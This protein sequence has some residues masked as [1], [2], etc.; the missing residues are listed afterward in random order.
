MVFSWSSDCTQFQDTAHSNV[1]GFMM[2]AAFCDLIKVDESNRAWLDGYIR[3]LEAQPKD[4][5]TICR[6]LSELPVKYQ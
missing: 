2:M 3:R 6:V 4:M 1:G 5:G